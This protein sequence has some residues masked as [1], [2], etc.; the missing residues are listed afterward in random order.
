VP[1]YGVRQAAGEVVVVCA[2][3]LV[4]DDELPPIRTTGDDV[5]PRLLV[6]GSC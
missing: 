3:I 4:L 6:L 2:T 5:D 1:G